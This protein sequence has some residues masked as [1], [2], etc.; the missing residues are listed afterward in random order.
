VESSPDNDSDVDADGGGERR[1]RYLTSDLSVTKLTSDPALMGIDRV[2][3]KCLRFRLEDR[4]DRWRDR[5]WAV[6][7]DRQ[8]AGGIRK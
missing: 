4:L 6:Q 3:R 1:K 7:C 2:M 8:P 5:R